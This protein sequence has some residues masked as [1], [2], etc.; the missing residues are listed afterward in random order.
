MFGQH[1]AY[2]N[3]RQREIKPI[4]IRSPRERKGDDMTTSRA[5][6][7]LLA[8]VSLSAFVVTAPAG[9]ATTVVPGI[10]SPT[11]APNVNDTIDISNIGHVG[12][13]EVGNPADAVVNAMHPQLRGRTR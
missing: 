7:A 1:L 3:D 12:V 6:A 13:Y 11:V 9:A 4:L 2:Y 10:A 5:R 8:T